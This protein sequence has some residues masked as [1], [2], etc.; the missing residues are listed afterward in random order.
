MDGTND[1]PAPAVADASPDVGSDEPTDSTDGDADAVATHE[2]DPELARA[3]AVR[4][5]AKARA[6]D[7]EARAGVL[8]QSATALTGERDNAVAELDKYKQGFT[9]LASAA[10]DRCI[11]KYVDDKTLH[12]AARALLRDVDLF[13]ADEDAIMRVLHE[14]GLI[15]PIN[16]GCAGT[17]GV[18]EANARRTRSLLER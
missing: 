17:P 11:V 14:H 3:I 4:D 8:E 5:K 16:S 15:K 18:R 1:I 7:A 2:K 12:K 6:R 13:T 9:R 10:L